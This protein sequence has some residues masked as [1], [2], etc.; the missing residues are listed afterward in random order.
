MFWYNSYLAY[1]SAASIEVDF[2][3]VHYKTNF[4]ERLS[5]YNKGAYPDY[6]CFFL[7]EPNK[8]KLFGEYSEKLLLWKSYYGR[9]YCID[10]TYWNLQIE[11]ADGSKKEFVGENGK[12][13][14]FE[15]FVIKFEQLIKKPL[16]Y[17]SV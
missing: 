4:N 13:E 14:D 10:G 17:K 8:S 1:E 15:E 2:G 9:G 5:G 11:L 12:P 3:K 6:E 7:V 16:S